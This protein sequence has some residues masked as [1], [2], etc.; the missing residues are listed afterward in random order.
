[1]KALEIRP[2]TASDFELY[3]SWCTDEQIAKYI[4]PID[5]EWL[6]HVLDSDDGAEF[7]FWHDGTMIAEVGIL[8]PTSDISSAVITNI[9][10]NPDHQRKG[11]GSRVMD[12]LIAHCN[13][14]SSWHCYVD[15]SNY[16]AQR[17]FE[18][19]NWGRQEEKGEMIKYCY[20]SS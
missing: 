18:S 16:R 4:G 3:S 9:T 1:M 19:K 13:D 7:T 17:F 12:T 5:R 2:F 10:I 15:Q 14:Y 6:E 11:W 20:P 8:F